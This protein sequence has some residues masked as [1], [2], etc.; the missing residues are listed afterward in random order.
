MEFKQF[1]ILGVIFNLTIYILKSL[2]KNN[3][4][5]F[6]KNIEEETE[7]LGKGL[8]S[9]IFILICLTSWGL[10]IFKILDKIS[11]YLKK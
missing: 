6:Q 4:E 10:L 8:I 1:Y 2:N 7:F 5:E 3:I 11:E 9:F